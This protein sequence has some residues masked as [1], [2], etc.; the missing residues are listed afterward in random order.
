MKMNKIKSHKKYRGNVQDEIRNVYICRICGRHKT[1]YRL[2]GLRCDIPGH[3]EQENELVL[4]EIRED[5]EKE[6]NSYKDFGSDWYS[7]DNPE[8]EE[9]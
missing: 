4:K 7:D 6:D 1:H 8:N 5:N 9:Q 2:Y 3:S